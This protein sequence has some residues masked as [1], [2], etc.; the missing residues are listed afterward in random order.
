MRRL[1]GF[2]WIGVCLG[3]APA[4]YGHKNSHIEVG[5][6]AGHFRLSQAKTSFV[7][8]GARVGVGILPHIKL[9]AEMSYDF[10]GTFTDEG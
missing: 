2:L 7:G 8:A 9:E 3:I 4:V 6:L 10:E 1:A 5:V